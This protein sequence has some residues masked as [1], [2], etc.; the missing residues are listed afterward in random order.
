M[1]PI[2]S[3]EAMR[4]VDELTL[5][6]QGITALDLMERA[7]VACT[8]RLLE[9]L[10]GGAFGQATA[11]HVLAG[12]GNNGGD[13]LVIA[14]QMAARSVPVR[15]TVVHHRSA[16]TD[17][18]RTNLERSKQSG[19]VHDHIHASGVR[20]DVADHEVVVDCLLGA[21][22]DRPLL[23]LLAE[24]VD[25]VNALP[26]PVIAI[27]LPSGMLEPGHSGQEGSCLHADRTLTFE[28]P[29]PGLL[30]AGTG[31]RAGAWEL[32]PIGS[33]AAAIHEVERFGEW[34]AEA[35]VRSLLLDRGR[36]AHKG[37][38]GH[39]LI[40]AGS[41][42]Y[43]GAA[44]LAALGCARSGAG[45]FTLHA[46]SDT[47]RGLHTVL[48]DA[49]T[50]ADVA[51]D[52]VTMMPDLQRATALGIGPGLG[53]AEETATVVQNVL[54]NWTASVVL[55]ADALNIIAAD[56]ACLDAI[57]K[58]AVLTP[59][60]KE[61]DRL[62]GTNCTTAYERLMR[63]KAFARGHSC[64]VVLKGAY[65]AIC[66]PDGRICFSATGN[67]GMAKGGSG[68]VLTGLLT[69]LLAQG[70]AAMD[71]CLI[72]VHLHGTAGDL[73]SRVKGIDAMRAT[74]LADQLPAAWHR[75]RG[76]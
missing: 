40:I 71:A 17:E 4:R 33:D 64:H 43:H 47:I 56:H 14:R 10:A 72:G 21:G 11:F 41:A 50:S 31:E 51:T 1:I 73:A 76:R 49:M 59:H 48:P 62:L 35:D 24:V 61:M 63:T 65:T 55:D 8:E 44:V 67:V 36:F 29:R 26:N 9:L 60:P 38:F 75:L 52:R 39:A 30:L 16:A 23:G 15:V 42:G 22:C 53:R 25:Q 66:G 69:G 28:V 2:L 74:D 18:Q 20:L 19:I 37:T 58:H 27:D 3:S 5:E 68:D 46:P 70:Y 45:L 7:G 57:P 54:R 12:L 6:R 34:V 13:G 32:V